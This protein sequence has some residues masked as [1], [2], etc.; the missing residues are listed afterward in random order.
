MT[1][2][3]NHLSPQNQVEEQCRGAGLC[4]GPCPTG[5]P[6]QPHVPLPYGK[7]PAS[8]EHIPSPTLVDKG[9]LGPHLL[10]VL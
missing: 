9:A 4:Q 7:A 3:K 6:P 5:V 2:L 8:P 10:L 1:G